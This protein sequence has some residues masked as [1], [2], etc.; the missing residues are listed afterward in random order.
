MMMLYD[1]RWTQCHQNNITRQNKSLCSILIRLTV[2]LLKEVVTC[3]IISFGLYEALNLVC[4]YIWLRIKQ[5]VKI[6]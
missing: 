1:D 2:K 3:F 6:M 4:I 5:N